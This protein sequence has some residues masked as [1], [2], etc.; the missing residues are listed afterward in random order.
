M[1]GVDEVVLEVIPSENEEEEPGVVPSSYEI[2][3]YRTDFTLQGLY[4]K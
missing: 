1:V 3:V 4:D 2:A